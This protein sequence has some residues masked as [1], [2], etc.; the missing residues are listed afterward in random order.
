MSVELK[1]YGVACNLSCAYCYQN[2]IRNA[3]RRKPYDLEKMKAAAAEAGGPFTLFGGE[4]LLMPI[5]DVE[6]LLEWGF[7]KYG[8]SHIQTNGALLKDAHIELFKKYNVEVGISIDGPGELND[9]RFI[10][11]AKLTRQTTAYIESVIEKLCEQ[12]LAPGLIVTL[13]RKNAL[14]QHLPIM[15]DW[16]RN[17]DRIGVDSCRLHLLEVDDPSV[18]DQAA[19]TIEQ[20]IAALRNFR[21]LETELK[22]LRF[23]LF[24]EMKRLL[25]GEDEHTSCVWNACDPY[26]TE[27]VHGIE[28]D[29]QST[30]CGRTNKDGIDYSKASDRGFERY[31]ALYRAPQSEG[32]CSGCRFFFACKGQCPGTALQGDWRQRTEHCGVWKAMFSEAEEELVLKDEFP[33]SISP[34]RHVVEQNLVA[35][36]SRN[37][38][39]R[40]R[41]A[42]HS[43]S[44]DEAALRRRLSGEQTP[45][46]KDALFRVAYV[47]QDAERIWKPRIAAIRKALAIASAARVAAERSVFQVVAPRAA[48]FALHQRLAERELVV[49]HH[50]SADR[51][52]GSPSPGHIRAIVHRESERFAIDSLIDGGDAAALLSL[53]REPTY[54]S[55]PQLAQAHAREHWQQNESLAVL[56]LYWPNDMREAFMIEEGFENE[57]AW[58][59]TLLQAPVAYSAKSGIAEAKTRWFKLSYSSAA[60]NNCEWTRAGD[61][62][63]SLVA[64]AGALAQ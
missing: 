54:C 35:A 14:P 58:L 8:R 44:F 41:Y 39:T 23:D 31:L 57:L 24:D 11:N 22:T 55:A 59:Q 63:E 4:P 26:N 13:H 1:P 2:P 30:N 28:G 3:S 32:G 47:S 12:G 53:L 18:R 50:E 9:L 40:I 43:S 51:L 34:L 21:R 19:L 36:W 20:N 61:S 38:N 60:L 33:I 64:C 29:G 7:E 45:F 52:L 56:G 5:D 17:W 42:M 62:A 6:S 15:N 46:S 27:A 49:R 37:K 48:F 25:M 16:I 10:R